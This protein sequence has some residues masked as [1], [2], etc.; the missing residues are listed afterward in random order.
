MMFNTAD[1]EPGES[2]FCCPVDNRHRFQV[3]CTSAFPRRVSLVQ[4]AYS[5]QS[6]SATRTARYVVEDVGFCHCETS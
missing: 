6:V 1:E 4:V 2:C 3:Y 5:V